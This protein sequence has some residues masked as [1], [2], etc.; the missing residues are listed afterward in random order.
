M[1]VR[2]ITK[3]NPKES[4]VALHR[5]T[6][7]TVQD[8]GST[9]TPDMKLQ[10]LASLS[11]AQ[12]EHTLSGA[13]QWIQMEHDISKRLERQY[14]GQPRRVSKA[15]PPFRG[16]KGGASPPQNLASLAAKGESAKDYIR[17]RQQQ[18]RK[19]RDE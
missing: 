15:P 3:G 8:D 1:L 19:A 16:P 18:M 10:Y 5:L 2:E 14:A 17:A 12:L 4:L 11:P 6:M 13:R 7:P 9:V